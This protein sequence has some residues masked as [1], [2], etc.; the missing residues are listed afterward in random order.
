MLAQRYA[1]TS[2]VIDFKGILLHTALAK[3]RHPP[4]VETLILAITRLLAL[5]LGRLAA[6]EVVVDVAGTA[7][8]QS[9]TAD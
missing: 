4:D 3:S 1:H 5:E 6:Y 8:L 9:W 2:G 7:K